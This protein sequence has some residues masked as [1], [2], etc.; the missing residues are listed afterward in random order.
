MKNELQGLVQTNTVASSKSLKDTLLTYVY[1]W[2]FFLLSLAVGL[3]L[4]YIKLRYTEPLYE[5]NTVINVKGETTTSKGGGGGGSNDLITSAMQGGRSVI[6]LDNELGRLRSARLMTLVVRKSDLNISYYRVGRFIKLDIFHEAPLRLIPRD[7][8]DSSHTISLSIDNPTATGATLQYGSKENPVKKIVGWNQNFTVD[9]NTYQLTPLTT[10]FSVVD[11]FVVDWHPTLETVYELLPKVSVNV[12]GRTSNIALGITIENAK[13]GEDVL[14]KMVDVFKQMNLDD[15]NQYALDKTYFIEER[16][17][18]LSDELKGVEKNLAS[19]QGSNLMVGQTANSTMG[20]PVGDAQKQIDQINSQKTLINMIRANLASPEARTLPTTGITDGTLG[21][22]VGDYNKSVLRRQSLANQVT[23]SSPLLKDVDEQIQSLKGNIIDNVSS[24]LRALDLQ[25]S[26]FSR[27]SAQF[28]SSVSVLPEKE[29][30]M[31]EISREK[32]IKES[33]YMYLLQK[34]E[35]TQLSK[36]TTSPY[37][38]IDLASSYGPVSPNAKTTYLYAGLL[39][40]ALPIGIIFLIGLLNDKVAGRDEVENAVKLA[41]V[42]GEINFIKNTDEVLL[43]SITGGIVGEQFR[44]MRAN[45]N[46]LQ[47]SAEKQVILVTSSVSGEGKSFIS[48]NLAAVLSKT[49]K[50]VALLDFDLRKPDA[51]LP[52]SI[53]GKGIKDYLLGEAT[54]D[55]IGR[56]IGELPSLDLYPS[57]SVIADVG[58]LILGEKTDRLFE[59]L[60]ERYDCIV[61]N[62][63]PVAL[64][65]DGLILQ[66]YSTMVGYVIRD[67]KTK[68]KHLKF[69]NSLLESKKFDSTCIIYNGVRTGMKYGYYGYGYTKNNA[70]FDRDKQ[71]KGIRF[72]QK[73]NSPVV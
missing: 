14:N 42:V 1:Y 28:R 32:N 34:R 63:P 9:N 65:G 27:Q 54:L 49:G 10:R 48:L 46:F 61:I 73:K 41:P 40:L 55:E 4:G 16:L 26:M 8:Q 38:Q 56:P 69:L 21:S 60:Q 25:A 57:G 58:D 39:S 51:T 64:V 36:S 30:I 70:Y 22:L 47:R 67:R 62:T 13:R 12:I 24:S 6:N 37:E 29:R 45:L 50:K 72:F 18:K 33:L 11:K 44:I 52:T 3:G 15:Q 17:A 68:K 5:A 23:A 31:N 20:T 53:D 19:Y 66:K 43:P 59:E 7:I 71:K 35:E 2:P